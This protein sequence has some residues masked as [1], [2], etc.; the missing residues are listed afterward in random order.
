MAMDSQRVAMDSQ[1]RHRLSIGIPAIGIPMDSRGEG[2]LVRAIEQQDSRG[3]LY[4]QSAPTPRRQGTARQGY[5]QSA[6][7]PRQGTARLWTVSVD[8]EAGPGIPRDS[9]RRHRLS[10]GVP[11][12][13]RTVKLALRLGLAHLGDRPKHYYRIFEAWCFGARMSGRKGRI[14]VGVVGA[15][16]Y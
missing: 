13:G 7:T 1:R 2:F 14:C 12:P 10:I 15:E 9:Q 6:S 5:G 16:N 3:P 11:A 8:T 4:G